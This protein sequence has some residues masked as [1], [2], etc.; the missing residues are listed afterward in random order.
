MD[1]GASVNAPVEVYWWVRIG[2]HSGQ[3]LGREM[4]AGILFCR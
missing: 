4:P 3:G 2:V 1:G